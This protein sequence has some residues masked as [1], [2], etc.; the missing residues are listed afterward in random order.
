MISAPMAPLRNAPKTL[1]TENKGP[2]RSGRGRRKR[3]RG[4]ESTCASTVAAAAAA[5]SAA[6]LVAALARFDSPIP[7]AAAAPTNTEELR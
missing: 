2:G 1:T 4:F 6:V 7:A 3:G 5:L